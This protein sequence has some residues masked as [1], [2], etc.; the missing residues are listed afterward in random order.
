MT[1]ELKPT[2]ALKQYMQSGK[3]WGKPCKLEELKALTAE[4]RTEL[5]LLALEAI[6]QGWE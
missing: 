2:S 1:E 4:E 5:G 3:K 6:K